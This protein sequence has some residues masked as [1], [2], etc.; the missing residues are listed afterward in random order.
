VALLILSTL[1]LAGYSARNLRV[2][3]QFRD[4]FDFPANTD[5]P[6]FKQ[7][8]D[9]FGDPAGF[10]VVL[11]EGEDV[12]TPQ[13]VA[14]VDQLTKAL[15]P[16]PEFL[17]VL[18]VTSTQAIRASGDDIASG[19]LVPRVPATA[20]ELAAAR[21]YALD[22]PLYKRRLVSA[23]GK[24]T[25]V[26]AEMRTPST[27][28]TIAEQD[29]ALATVRSKLATLPPP[30][31]LKAT[32]TGAPAVE[33]ETTRSLISDQLVLT[34][35][36]M[37]V[38][39]LCLWFT[40]RSMHGIVMCL[41]AVNVAVT[42]TAGIFAAM[43]RPVDMVGSVIP[44]ALLVYGVVDPIFL[45]A[46][47]LE[48][49]GDGLDQQEA[50]VQSQKELA[51]P[52][53]LTSI[54]TAIGFIAFVSSRAPTVKYY[55][56]TVGIGVLL[57]WVTTITVLPLL[58]SAV[59]PPKNKYFALSS[60]GLVLKFT[61]F[62]NHLA[63]TFPKL[64]T[65][66]AVALLAITT[67]YASKLAIVNE[68]VG[69][70]PV[71]QTQNEVRH[72]EERMSGTIRLILHLDGPADSM[73]RPDVLAA[74]A[75][76]DAAMDEEPDVTSSTSLARFVAEANQAFAG[77]DAAERLVPTSP[78]LISQY[79]AL[80]DPKDKRDVVT[81]DYAKAHVAVLV[82]DP[83]SEKSRAL[84]DRLAEAARSAGFEKL[85]IK[86]EVTGNGVVA[87]RELDLVV[88]EVF[89]G[90]LIAF[91]AILVI[92]TISFRSI[93][94]AAACLIPNLIPVSVCLSFLRAYGANLKVDTSLVLCI[95]IGGLY[96]TTIHIVERLK[97][98]VAAGER[99]QEAT[100]GRVLDSVAPP[101]F[102]TAAVLSAGFAV[103]TLSSFPGLQALG[104]LSLITLLTGF[105]AD[106]IIT[107]AI[108][109]LLFAWPKDSGATSAAPVRLTVEEIPS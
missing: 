41:T 4:F 51:L 58:L 33:T 46:R 84:A 21:K 96:N 97:Q 69:G 34:P 94:V 78:N 91:F 2:A 89:Q 13:V 82:K 52:C 14:Y 85:G 35:G 107:P 20:E 5:L 11:L 102:F 45:L 29:H 104:I 44:T 16:E 24:S 32:V 65:F 66:G 80:I 9:E 28:S 103:L 95:C 39:I 75:K 108:L 53:F 60:A 57:A 15:Q 47:Y 70:L 68:Y 105:L 76:V 77:G 12:F 50:I 92:S 62:T 90:F 106:V 61:R 55:G 26:L 42:W 71:G 63:A 19:P 31:G 67:A 74:M 25:A 79:L 8:N 93:R 99:E 83:G 88:H 101:S 36:V 30:G 40:F 72:M 38:L 23:D 22:S 109:Q 59:P 18:S 27:F 10:V 7:D 54:T 3:F 87:Y 43:G 81:D 6:L 64:I 56:I 100:M 73:N 98:R 48:K 37:G 17:R 86:A 1:A 49:L